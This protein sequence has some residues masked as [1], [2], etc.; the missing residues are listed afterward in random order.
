MVV[1]ELMEELGVGQQQMCV[2]VAAKEVAPVLKGHLLKS[3][4]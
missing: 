4:G 2:V 3:E 1:L